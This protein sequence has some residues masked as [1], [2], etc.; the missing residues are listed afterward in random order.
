M[1]ICKFAIG[2]GSGIIDIAN[3]NDIPH[4]LVNQM[5]YINLQGI[6]TG[7]FM[8]KIFIKSNGEVLKLMGII[9]SAGYERVALVAKLPNE[10]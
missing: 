6:K 10:S 4:G 1:L 3:L 8:P 7:T 5:Q 2:T 9:Q